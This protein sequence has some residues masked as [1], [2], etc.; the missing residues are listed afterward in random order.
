MNI[1]IKRVYENP[2]ISDGYR[3][4]VDRLWP[5]GLTK[6]NSRVDLWEKNVAP[7]NELRKQYHAE[8]I[9]WAEFVKAYQKELQSSSQVLRDFLA[10]LQGQKK[11]TFLFSS[12][13]EEK[14][15]ATALKDYLLQMEK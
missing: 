15:N 10:K 4:L 9:N 6:E 13:N 8:S 7:S 12:K 11:V 3:V 14:N 5:R 2:S 1:Q